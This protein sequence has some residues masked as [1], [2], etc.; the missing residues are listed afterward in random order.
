[1]DSHLFIKGSIFKNLIR[2]S[3]PYLLSCF[4]QTFY[5]LADL[6]IVGQFNGASS[7]S[8]VSVGS[9]VMHMFTVIIVG[10]AVGASVTISRLLGEKREKDIPYIIGNTS[11][12]F[13]VFS[14]VATVVLIA[15]IPGIIQVLSV[16]YEAIAETKQYLTVCFSG[17]IF[18]AAYN[19][20]S[21]IFRGLGDSQRPM[22]FVAVAG[23]VNVGLD[24]LFIGP[25]HSGAIGA[26]YATVIAQALSVCFALFYAVK[27]MN[28]IHLTKQHFLLQRKYLKDLLKIGV[29]IALQDGFIQISFLVITVIANRRGVDVA[30]AVGIVEKVISFMFLVPSAMLSGVSTICA[31]NA[32]ASYHQR[33]FKTLY[34][35]IGISCGIGFVFC[36]L[37]QFFSREILMLF[38]K[39][40]ETVIWMGQQYLRAYSLDCIF[41]AV[42]FCFSGFFTAYQKSYISFLHNMISIVLVRIPGAYLAAILFQDSLYPMGLAAP[43]G[44]ILSIVICLYFFNMVKK[45]L[46]ADQSHKTIAF[47]K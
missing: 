45:R 27:K 6:F 8:A 26:A 1:M 14:I 11:I 38:A 18:I 39:E 19:V 28:F 33:A 41:A 4:L 23:I 13:L 37:S 7:I 24:Y 34:C 35:G 21:N 31:Q 40:E 47:Y 20:I 16:P 30:A 5:G 17:L 2:F 22:Y 36:L 25:M 42:H 29:P 3:L 43:A 32:G 15:A 12:F 44:S 10:L 9:Q 46:A